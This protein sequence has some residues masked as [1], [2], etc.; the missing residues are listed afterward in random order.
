[1]TI[2]NKYIK[3]LETYTYKRTFPQELKAYELLWSHGYEASRMMKG[4]T[5]TGS[6]K[7]FI[8]SLP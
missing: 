5:H 4:V 2:N 8:Q 3:V 7:E 6:Y 1:M